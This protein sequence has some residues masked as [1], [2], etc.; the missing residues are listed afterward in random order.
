M[1]GM[2]KILKKNNEGNRKNNWKDIS[3]SWISTNP[4]SEIGI[5]PKAI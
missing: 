3:C 4:F 1:N 2:C 5:L